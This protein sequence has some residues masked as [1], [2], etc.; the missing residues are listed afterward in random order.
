M[1]TNNHQSYL[2]N[3]KFFQTQLCCFQYKYKTSIEMLLCFNYLKLEILTVEKFLSL[4]TFS[5]QKS[6]IVSKVY[7]N[8]WLFLGCV[9]HDQ[10]SLLFSQKCI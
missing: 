9:L 1:F 5:N 10:V 4:V 2:I 3:L 7:S 6:I 8:I